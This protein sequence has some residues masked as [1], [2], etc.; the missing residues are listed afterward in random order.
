MG[1][2][3]AR[4]TAAAKASI[5]AGKSAAAEDLKKKTGDWARS[6][7]SQEDVD[8]LKR[9]DL[10]AGMEYRIPG[11]EEI[12]KP[13]KGWRVI[14][15]SFLFRGL[16]L[17]AHE[18]LRGLL[19]VYGLQLYHL[20]PNSLLHV[21][22]FITFCECYLGIDPH[23]GLWKS[24]YQVRGQSGDERYTIGG[25]GF[26][27]KSSAKFLENAGV[28]SVQNWRNKWFYVKDMPVENQE[29]NLAA[30][31]DVKADN[32]PSWQNKLT[33]K[34]RLEV[35]R[36][37]PRVE[38]AVNVLSQE[39]GFVRLISIFIGRRLQPLQA[40]L[41]PMW[42]YSGPSDASRFGRKDFGTAEGLEMAI[43]SIIK[44]KKSKKLPP[45]CSLAPFGDDNKLPEVFFRLVLAFLSINSR[46]F[47]L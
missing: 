29:E 2:K 5:A 10:L 26:S 37:M 44:G 14:F 21:A 23:W 36:L 20:T 40:R 30:F 47:E 31:V 18:F 43:K 24:L 13:P 11:D 9:Q 6:T 19:F 15:F 39:Y 25:C 33:K 16:S 1:K 8:E 22:V 3:S 7:F 4:N 34:E 28:D 46:F 38:E 27:V 42:E 32:L 17:P 12:P 41:T 45:P 35:K